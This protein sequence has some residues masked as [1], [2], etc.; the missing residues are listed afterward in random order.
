MISECRPCS[1]CFSGVVVVDKGTSKAFAGW[2]AACA[3]VVLP[4]L[5]S[6]FAEARARGAFLALGMIGCAVAMGRVVQWADEVIMAESGSHEESRAIS[7]LEQALGRA[8]GA[9][10]K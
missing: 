3:P 4:I 2:C 5:E 7:K 9:V 6:C 8:L 10:W 1:G